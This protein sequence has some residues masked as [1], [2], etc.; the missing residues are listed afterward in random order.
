MG[1]L[2]AWLL[3]KPNIHLRTADADYL[4]A[5]SSWLATLLPRMSRWLYSRGGNIISVQVENEYG[6]Y[7]ACDYNYLRHLRA[8]FQSFLGEDTL[9]FTT[10]GNT[11]REMVCGTLQGLYATIDFGTDTNIST[12]FARQR[13]FEPKG[14]LV[15][16]EFYTGW[17]DHWGDPHA[18]VDSN[19]VSKMLEEMLAM[20]AN[21]NMYMFE[22]GTNFGYWNGA[23]HDS[24]YRSV[25]TSYDYNAPL[26]EAGDPTDKLLAI[27]EVI[28][29]VKEFPFN[30]YINKCYTILYYTIWH[31][32]MLY[33]NTLNWPH[34]SSHPQDGVRL[35]HASEGASLLHLYYTT[36][37]CTILHYSIL[38][39]TILYY[40]ASSHFRGC[41]LLTP[42]LHYATL[43]YTTLYYATL[44]YTILH[45]FVTLQRVRPSHTYTTLCYTVLYYTIVYYTILHCTIL[46][47]TILYYI[48]W[49][50][51]TSEGASFS[52]LYYT[53]LHCTIPHYTTLCY[54]RGSQ[55]F[56]T[57]DGP[58]VSKESKALFLEIISRPTATATPRGSRPPLGEPLCYTIL[59]Y[60]ALSYGYVLL[61]PILYDTILH[62]TIPYY[63]ILYYTTPHYTALHYTTLHYT[64]LHGFVMR[65]GNVSGLLDVL[66][67]QGPV[68]SHYPL[69]FEEMKH[70]YGFVL[71]RTKLPRTILDGQP[72][73]SPRNGI[74][75]RAYVSVNGVYQ[76]LLERDTALVMNVTGQEGD[77]LDLLVENMGRVNFGSKI[78]DNKGI[79]GELILGNNVLTDWLIFS[80]DLDGAISRGWPH[81]GEHD[82]LPRPPGAG[83]AEGAGPMVYKGTLP[84]NGLAW[85]TYIKLIGWTKVNTYIHTHTH[86]HT[87]AHL[88]QTHWLDQSE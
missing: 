70:Y 31:Y 60:M 7:F 67:P 61:T 58:L 86:T 44:Y 43:Y 51:H 76:G 68:Q 38:H 41:V 25:V 54:T 50:R 77:Q 15:N 20:G 11:D 8:L 63:T 36:L 29:K 59:Y 26:T 16:S 22:G 88:H 9:L 21:V 87:Y 52:H 46:C 4:Q 83:P 49:L 72:L 18:S 71:Y 73:I 57:G 75:D 1:G 13:R 85:D 65:V 33:Y 74:H 69:T 32:T 28:R 80:V 82:W 39:Y 2:P 10:D 64:I 81:S 84:P 40:M 56:Q 19:K 78:H 79:L 62:Y 47:Y 24:R 6:S 53:T 23:D 3:E 27:R 48:T 12:A 35:R 34:A 30:K 45:G 5:V 14:P 66:T 55:I 17:L 42:I 37:H